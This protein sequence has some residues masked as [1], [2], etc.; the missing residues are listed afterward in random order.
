MLQVGIMT[1]WT[2][3]GAS[4]GLGAQF[5]ELLSQK[6]PE[7]SVLSLSRSQPK[8]AWGL[9]KAADFSDPIE[10]ERAIEAILAQKSNHIIYFAGGGPYGRY[11]KPAWKDHRWAFEVTFLFA[12]RLL[13]AVLTRAE[14]PTVLTLIGSSVAEEGG[15]PGA[16]AYAASKAAL[17]SMC[18]TYH[19][20]KSK[21]DLRRYSPG[22]MDTGLLPSGA[23]PRRYPEQI[24]PPKEVAEDLYQFIRTGAPQSCR[25]LTPYRHA[26]LVDREPS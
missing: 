14:E 22:Y 12:A 2:L 4:R 8:F 9:W 5:L 15:D 6:E 26:F 16:L 23:F 20:E 7:S 21:V 19:L 17:K 11:E 1:S 10:Q 18:E 25:R 24:W 3:L 13:H